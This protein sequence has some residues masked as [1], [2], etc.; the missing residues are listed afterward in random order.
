MSVSFF[1]FDFPL[2]IIL[3]EVDFWFISTQNFVL[4]VTFCMILMNCILTFLFL[5]IYNLWWILCGYGC[6]V[7]SLLLTSMYAYILESITDLLC[8]QFFLQH[9]FSSHPQYYCYTVYSPVFPCTSAFLEYNQLGKQTAFDVPDRFQLW[10]EHCCFL[11]LHSHI[12][13]SSLSYT[14]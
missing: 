13:Q 11:H 7:F 8:S 5:N 6:E 1:F 14:N 9:L 12:F 4:L 3:I 2:W 10:F